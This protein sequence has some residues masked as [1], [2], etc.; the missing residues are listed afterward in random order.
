VQLR[1]KLDAL[2]QAREVRGERA[3]VPEIVLEESLLHAAQEVLLG[4]AEAVT[5]PR[6][7]LFGQEARGLALARRAAALESATPYLRASSLNT[8]A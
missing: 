1:Q 8:L 7:A 4:L 2:R 6:R 5:E 3:R